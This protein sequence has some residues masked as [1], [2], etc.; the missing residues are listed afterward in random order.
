MQDDQ[1]TVKITTGEMHTFM[2]SC[3]IDLR[4]HI[5]EVLEKDMKLDAFLFGYWPHEQFGSVQ[6]FGGG[7]Q[8][9]LNNVGKALALHILKTQP[10]DIIDER[11]TH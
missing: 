9:A 11:G 1:E 3:L 8:G 6:T 7:L 2:R 5:N 4:D 10:A